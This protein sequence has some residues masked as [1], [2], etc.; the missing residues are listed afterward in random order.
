LDLGGNLEVVVP[1]ADYR[2]TL[3]PGDVRAFDYL[4]KAARSVRVMPHERSGHDAYEDANEAVLSSCEL[5]FAVWD[6]TA[7]LERAGTTAVVKAARARG[8][9]VKVI[10]PTGAERRRKAAAPGGG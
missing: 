1:A 8:L 9:P 3:D 7:A 4:V 6:P 5:M 10:W 2:S